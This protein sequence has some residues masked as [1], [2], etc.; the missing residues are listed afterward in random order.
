M[1]SLGF[2][3]LVSEFGL[4]Y[5]ANKEFTGVGEINVSIAMQFFGFLG[6]TYHF[7]EISDR[8]SH[9]FNCCSKFMG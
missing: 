7:D 8:D 9:F 1:D 6:S 3:R 5:K 4:V 2:E